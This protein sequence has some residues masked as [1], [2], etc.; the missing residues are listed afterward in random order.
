MK[1]LK[2]VLAVL[3]ALCLMLC[4]TVP[5]FAT[6]DVAVTSA[7]VSS[8]A[9]ATEATVAG[10]ETVEKDLEGA[11]PAADPEE[12]D[13]T[14]TIGATEP[15][16]DESGDDH[17]GHDH[18]TEES[19]GRKALRVTLT[20]LEVIASLTL[21][22]VV[23]I[24]SGKESGLSGAIAGNNDS[25]MSKGNRATLDKKLATMTKWVALLWVALTLALSLI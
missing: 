20:V 18:P 23:L 22:I 2:P 3:A 19:A 12:G 14:V 10:T 24:Q 16:V 9:F 6:E 15:A 13:I 5:V 21:I 7:S 1:N 25:Y 8:E 4:L 11:Q 17:E